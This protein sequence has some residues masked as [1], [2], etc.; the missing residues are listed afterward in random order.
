MISGLV[1]L[2]IAVVAMAAVLLLAVG[3]LRAGERGRPAEQLQP[4]DTD[5]FRN[6]ISQPEE[7]YLREHLPPDEFRAVHRERMLAA[8]EYVWGAARNASILIR[9]AEST[10]QNADGE[11]IA[12]AERLQDNAFRLRLYAWQT[13]PR[14]YFAA[15]VPGAGSIPQALAESYDSLSR[16]MITLKCMQSAKLS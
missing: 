13:L 11:L 5:A 15:W 10:K 7:L 1:M 12:S 16:Q 4:I 14:L 6:L 3:R 2:A 8:S 9:L